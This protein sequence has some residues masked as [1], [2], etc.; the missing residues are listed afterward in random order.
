[1][2]QVLCEF[3]VLTFCYIFL[4]FAL[5]CF[6]IIIIGII[7]VIIVLWSFLFWFR[8][9]LEFFINNAS[10]RYVTLTVITVITGITLVYNFTLT[11]L[12]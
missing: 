9:L 6:F 11:I 7:R 3:I 8:G 2:I 10:A 1:M 5:F 12:S 4:I